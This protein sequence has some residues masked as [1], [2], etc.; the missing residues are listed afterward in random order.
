M[1][2][3]IGIITNEIYQK[4]FLKVVLWNNLA[5]AVITSAFRRAS[6]LSITKKGGK[7][8]IVHSAQILQ[9]PVK[10]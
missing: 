10:I 9:S 4:G 6:H 2:K 8:E 5:K 3:Q 7:I 1:L